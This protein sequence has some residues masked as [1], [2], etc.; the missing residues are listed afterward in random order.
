MYLLDLKRHIGVGD[1]GVW[2]DVKRDPDVDHSTSGVMFGKQSMTLPLRPALYKPSDVTILN[3][4]NHRK[5]IS[6]EKNT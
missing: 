2:L 6:N 1:G 5:T 4:I 3:S